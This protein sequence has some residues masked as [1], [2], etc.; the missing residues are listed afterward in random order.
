MKK[1]GQLAHTRVSTALKIHIGPD[2]PIQKY[3]DVTLSLKIPFRPSY[4]T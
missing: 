2:P 3:R 1:A 4:Q